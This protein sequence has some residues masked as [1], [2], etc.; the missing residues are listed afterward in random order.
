M[1]KDES[2][3][4]D[5]SILRELRKKE[6]MSIADLTSRS[7]VSAAVISKLERNQITAGLETIGKLA[8]AF[9][10]SGSDLIKLAERR[11]AQLAK[12]TERNTAGFHFQ[13]V[14]FSHLKGLRGTAPAG[15]SLERP[16]LHRDGSEMCWVL[17]GK[18][19]FNLPDG[20]Y[21]LASGEAIMFDSMLH[22]RYEVLESCEIFIVHH[23]E[24]IKL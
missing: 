8:R 14:S 10:I 23:K 15:V 4:Y 6:Q 17:K 7:G 3:L 9:A 24:G 2:G 12:A 21:E 19:R 18:V 11:H 13:E 22:H 16:H 1:D 5:F 20:D